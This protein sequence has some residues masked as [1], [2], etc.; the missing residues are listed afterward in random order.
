MNKW[1]AA[2]GEVQQTFADALPPDPLVERKKMFGY[3]A[4]FVN[5]NM[6]AGVFQDSI[7]VRLPAERREAL[8]R[9]GAVPFEPMGRPMREYV[10]VPAEVL[11]SAKSLKSWIE[12]S[13]TYAK[14]LPPKSKKPRAAR[15]K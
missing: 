5:G 10:V 8:L 11:R 3:P 1:Q 7:V 2:P 14:S 12:R 13:L 15:P 6:F 4:A 9:E